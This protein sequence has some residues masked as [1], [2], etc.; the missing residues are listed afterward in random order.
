MSWYDA[1][2]IRG[3]LELDA[4]RADAFVGDGIHFLHPVDAADVLLDDEENATF[5]L[6]GAGPRVRHAD[7]HHVQVELGE[8]LLL[9]AG[10]HEEATDE[11]H[12]H[13]DVGQDPVV[14]HARDPTLALRLSRGGRRAHGLLRSAFSPWIA[15]G[16]PSTGAPRSVV[17]TRSP[18]SNP[19]QR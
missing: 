5:H 8:H 4:D 11:Q 10:G 6:L 12:E 16:M 1:L 19:E 3:R 9:D 7:R 17:I 14:D 18:G 2:L 13:D 15:R